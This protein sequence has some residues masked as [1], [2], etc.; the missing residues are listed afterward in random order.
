MSPVQRVYHIFTTRE[1]SD[2]GGFLEVRRF[3]LLWLFGFQS[4]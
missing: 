4:K 3:C 2:L 1:A